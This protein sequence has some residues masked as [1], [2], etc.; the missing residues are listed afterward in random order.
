MMNAARGRWWRTAVVAAVALLVL[1]GF[2]GWYQLLRE[3]PQPAFPDEEARFKYGSLGAE[4]DRGIPYWVWVV[5]PRVFPDL[6]PGPGGYAS[7]G[8]AW[9]PGQELPVGFSKK[10][11]GF[12]R[13]TNNCAVCH[14]ARYRV[15]EDA[16][17]VFVTGGPAHASDIQN[18]IRFLTRCA[19]DPRFESRILLDE[20]SRV[21]GLSWIERPLYRYVVIP[22]TRRALL[23]QK[24]QFAWM[25]R[26]GKPHW[27][28]GRDDP[29]NLTK[30]FMTGMPEDD[31]TGQADF[32]SI[33]NLRIRKGP[34]LLLNW[35]GDTPAVRS[36]I[37]DSALGLGAPPGAPFLRRME[38]IDA[39]LSDRPP[40]P[41]PAELPIDRA[42]AA[43]GEP[44]YRQHCASCHDVGAPYTNKVV[45]LAELGTDPERERTWTAEAAARANQAVKDMGIDRPPMLKSPPGYVSPPLDGVWLRAP[46]LHNGSVPNM[47][48]LLMPPAS[49]PKY[50]FRGNDVI[51]A[52]ALGFASETC[53][54]APLRD[55]TGRDTLGP[56]GTC[57]ASDLA[58]RPQAPCVRHDTTLRGNGNGGHDYGTGLPEPQK[59][60]LVEY[61][62]TL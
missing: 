37:I 24:E 18:N 40:P 4:G 49:R 21:Y 3:V 45:P 36:V 51:D 5:L 52:D 27:L 30:Y 23:R 32:P 54:R 17:P 7:L 50:F 55:D 39:F 2:V 19:E 15:R 22:L 38:E 26:P 29:M 34:D 33:W 1:A 35:S 41:W 12:P 59:A 8:L 42:L 14:T 25:D 9:E 60:A 58:C 10:T 44:V 11:V 48:A 20:I 13:V 61:L 57:S 47:R 31:T 53:A 46:Y 28:P 62:K 6:L 16:P 56:D 43:T